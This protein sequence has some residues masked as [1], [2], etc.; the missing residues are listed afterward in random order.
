MNGPAAARAGNV[1]GRGARHP[2]TD[3]DAAPRA[4]CRTAGEG[5]PAASSTEAS[6]HRPGGRATA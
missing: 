4:W 6:H 1:P 2:G 3:D 5:D